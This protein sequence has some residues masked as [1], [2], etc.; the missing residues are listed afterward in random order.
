MKKD[1]KVYIYVDDNYNIFIGSKNY[2]YKKFIDNLPWRIVKKHPDIVD[3]YGKK[4]Y[5][6]IYKLI[7]DLYTIKSKA[8]P[9]FTRWFTLIIGNEMIQDID[10]QRIFQIFDSLEKTDP[11]YIAS[12]SKNFDF[13]KQSVRE[14]LKEIL[15]LLEFSKDKKPPLGICRSLVTEIFMAAYLYN[16]KVFFQNHN[17]WSYSEQWTKGKTKIEHDIELYYMK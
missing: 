5:S 9:I 14:V 11:K 13:T 3:L 1:Y 8:S 10:N 6:Q 7:D 16:N 4:K 17:Y 12:I 15:N 2:T